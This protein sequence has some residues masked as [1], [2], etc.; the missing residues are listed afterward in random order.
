MARLGGWVVVRLT[1]VFDSARQADIAMRHVKA[2]I[3]VSVVSATYLARFQN[4]AKSGQNELPH[5][6]R[7]F[8]R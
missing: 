7:S 4:Q 8:P 1:D 2:W 6:S 3:A 5:D